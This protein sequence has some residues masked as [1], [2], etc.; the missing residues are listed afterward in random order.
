[1][2]SI[3]AVLHAESGAFGRGAKRDGE[4]AGV[5]GTAK[6]IG[7]DSR[8]II[9]KRCERRR[10]WGAKNCIPRA[11]RAYSG[12]LRRAFALSCAV[13]DAD[14]NYVYTLGNAVSEP[15]RFNNFIRP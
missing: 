8:R 11:I 10:G 14:A 2:T 9:L 4:N 1:M 3:F 7:N 6:K 5:E 13:Q 15:V 12:T